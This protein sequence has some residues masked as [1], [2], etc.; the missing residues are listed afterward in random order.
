MKRIQREDADITHLIAH[1][2]VTVAERESEGAMDHAMEGEEEVHW[3]DDEESLLGSDV[4][5]S[6][7]SD[8]DGESE[9]DEDCWVLND[10]EIDSEC[11]MDSEGFDERESDSNSD[12]NEEVYYLYEI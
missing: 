9:E 8:S 6:D 11:D 3:E 2:A 7:A 10:D 4:S 5:A 1:D 12:D